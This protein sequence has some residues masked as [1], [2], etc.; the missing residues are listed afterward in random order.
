M[1][2]I[3]IFI[4]LILMTCL[5]S[6]TQAAVEPVGIHCPC[7]VV[8]INQTK[9]EVSFSLVMQPSNPIDSSGESGDLSLLI[10]GP[11]QLTIF[12]SSYYPFGEVDIPS[13]S[14]NDSI[15]E[16]ITVDVPVSYTHLTLPTMRLV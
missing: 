4:T 3:H 6:L 8:R 7:E 12:G 2:N 1:K 11:N 15:E 10:A 13:V 5:V 14:F 9:A 16:A